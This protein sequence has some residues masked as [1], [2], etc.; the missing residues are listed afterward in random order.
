MTSGQFHNGDDFA[1]VAVDAVCDAQLLICTLN[2]ANAELSVS[3][4]E[5]VA[6]PLNLTIHGWRCHPWY[7]RGADGTVD[8]RVRVVWQF[9]PQKAYTIGP[10]DPLRE[11][12]ATKCVALLRSLRFPLGGHQFAFDFAQLKLTAHNGILRDLVIS[13]RFFF[14]EIPCLN[15]LAAALHRAAGL[16]LRRR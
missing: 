7:R 13:R 3:L 4:H 9:R 14:D 1:R 5:G 6:S 2:A 10:V 16:P 12:V 15:P 8:P 11:D